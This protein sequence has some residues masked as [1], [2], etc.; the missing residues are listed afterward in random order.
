MSGGVGEGM[1]SVCVLCVDLMGL[2]SQA[3]FKVQKK[4]S[5]LSC[6]DEANVT[7]SNQ[8]SGR[9]PA[10]GHGQKSNGS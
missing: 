3:R 5:R 2:Q 10:T 8:R 7:Q 6:V 4:R 1:K 9:W